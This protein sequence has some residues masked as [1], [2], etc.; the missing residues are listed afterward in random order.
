MSCTRGLSK[1]QQNLGLL[2]LLMERAGTQLR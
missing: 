1:L 2:S